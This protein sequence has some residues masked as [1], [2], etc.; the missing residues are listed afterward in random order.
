MSVECFAE[1]RL[2]CALSLRNERHKKSVE[3]SFTL[4]LTARNKMHALINQE[5]YRDT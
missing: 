2:S 3:M 5:D 4:F 1:Y